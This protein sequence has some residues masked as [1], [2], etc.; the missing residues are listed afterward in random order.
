MERRNAVQANKEWLLPS[1]NTKYIKKKHTK[2][3]AIEVNNRLSVLEDPVS[4]Q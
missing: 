4:E 2:E 3:K 1:S